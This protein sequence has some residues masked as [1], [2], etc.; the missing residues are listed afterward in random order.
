MNTKPKVLEALE[1][2]GPCDV[3]T[4]TMH[5]EQ[6]E[7]CVNALMVNQLRK[8][9]VKLT[10]GVY[11]LTYKS[12]PAKT[13]H[14]PSA[15]PTVSRTKV[16]ILREILK[17]TGECFTATELSERSGMPVKN[18]SGLLANDVSKG[19]INQT[20][21]DG[22]SVYQWAAAK[23]DNSPL[24]ATA[25][26]VDNSR[27]LAAAVCPGKMAE[28]HP[29]IAT[30]EPESKGVEKPPF[31]RPHSSVSNGTLSVP[32]SKCLCDELVKIDDELIS[33][34]TRVQELTEARQLKSE[35][36]DLVT[37]LEALI[38]REHANN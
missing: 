34:N 9:M 21:T 6:S 31:T 37:K 10:D 1:E 8:G 11:H 26:N 38:G 25:P 19:V 12:A 15:E 7:S 2:I 14:K 30:T 20:K 35:M 18:I 28:S 27:L 13:A 3:T 22:R 23:E 32:N 4:L 16:E 36:L 24:S 29:F 33:L 5:M 17:D